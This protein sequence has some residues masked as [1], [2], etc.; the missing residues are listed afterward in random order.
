VTERTGLGTLEVAVLS[1]VAEVGTA[2]RTRYGKT[3]RVLDVLER[4]LAF[5]VRYAYPVVADLVVPWRLHLP[6]LEGYGN[7]GSQHGDQA[8][9]ARYTEVRLSP[10]G[11]LALAAERGEVGPV[12][13]GLIEGSLYRD[14]PVPPFS[15]T[16]VV[17]ALMTGGS[18]AGPP[19]LPTGGTVDGDI[20][21]L[22]AGRRARLTLG[23]T[24]VVEPGLL[25]I[26]EVPL[27]LQIDMVANNLSS[28][29]GPLHG[30]GRYADYVE[31]GNRTP[32]PV[33][34]V[35]DESSSR[36]GVRVVCTLAPG[37]DVEQ[38]RE[39]AQAVWP[40]TVEIDARLPAPMRQRLKTWDAA[41]GSGLAALVA[42]L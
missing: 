12:P 41:D 35:R 9:E 32:V 33:Q 1:A 19:V 36:V 40:V 20:K 21:A 10:V 3:S 17:E 2:R 6:L 5:G 25:I 27:G 37:A 31:D 26:T 22:L 30:R 34:S 38:A 16:R 11:A 23:C 24:F 13:L 15:P 29:A 8:S 42:L 7:W 18:D 14:G 4:D 28:L 39:W